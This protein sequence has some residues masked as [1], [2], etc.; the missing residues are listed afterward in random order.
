MNEIGDL[1]GKA[2]MVAAVYRELRT[3][4]TVQYSR[5]KEADRY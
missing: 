2:S 3:R 1:T 5:G 4:S